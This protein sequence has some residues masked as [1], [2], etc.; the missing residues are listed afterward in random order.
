MSWAIEE[1]IENENA[2]KR[3]RR[4]LFYVKKI[5][6]RNEEKLDEE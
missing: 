3:E 6:M 1:N 5:W 4:E 2:W